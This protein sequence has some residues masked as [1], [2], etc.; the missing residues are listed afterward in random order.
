M[1]GD[2]DAASLIAAE[3]DHHRGRSPVWLV[4][5]DRPVLVQQMYRWGARNCELHF[6]QVRGEVQRPRGVVLPTFL[7][8]TG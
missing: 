2:D 7:P 6:A 4:P 1:R 8:E 3:L 5:A